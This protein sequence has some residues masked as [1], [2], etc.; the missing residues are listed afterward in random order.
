MLTFIDDAGS[1]CRGAINMKIAKLHMDAQD[2]TRFEI[3]GK[4][5]VKYH[6]KANHV[7]EAK[8]WF[9]SLNNAI[10]YSKDEAKDEERRRTRD[11]EIIRQAKGDLLAPE[12][13]DGSS[14][15][16][17]TPSKTLPPS[18]TSKLDPNSSSRVSFQASTMGPDSALG[19]DAGSIY[20]SY[21][22]SLAVNDFGRVPTGP[23]TGTIDGEDD[24]MGDDTSSHEVKP[25]SKDAFNITA[26]S[27]KV[28][29]DLLAHVSAAV[30]AEVAKNP[31][32][33]VADPTVAS[34]WS[35]FD[36]AVSNLN[37]LVIDLLKISRDRDAYWQFRLDRE[38]DARRMWEDSMAR[39]VKE[40]EDLQ[41]SIDE[42]EDKRK[43]T[44]RAL[45]EALEGSSAPGSRQG[46]AQ[47]TQAAQVQKAMENLELGSGAR[48]SLDAERA[49]GRAKRGDRRKSVI[50]KFTDLSDSDDDDDEE[51][52]DAVDAGHIAVVSPPSSPPLPAYGSIAA[53]AE[54][55]QE[56][57][58]KEL[59]EREAKAQ[60]LVSSYRG[61]EEPIRKKLKMDADNRP[62]IS[63]WVG[64]PLSVR[65][66][67]ANLFLRV[68]S[69]P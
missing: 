10:Q 52:F 6:L 13:A 40:H 4:S 60:E 23:G 64:S 9:W 24:E 62:K 3:H 56:P 65:L 48:A 19:E 59:D 15:L 45:K 67:C 66:D 53:V 1:A 18:T 42:S 51:F 21:E 68:F 36:T 31:D 39:V 63:L 38:A 33:R 43:R 30:G 25:A 44:K 61:Y 37:A 11:T 8:R 32:M 14:Q 7:V 26:Q 29:L 22:P 50:E 27:A 28:Q 12:S 58:D 34:A 46:T 49:V 57:R 47:P 55:K 20:D 54:E 5:S 2:K 17:K 35:T 16:S 69:N 41:K